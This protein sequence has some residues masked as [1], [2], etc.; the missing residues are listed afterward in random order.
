MAI[1]AKQIVASRCTANLVGAR[2]LPYHLQLMPATESPSILLGEY[3]NTQNEPISPPCPVAC[4]ANSEL[5]LCLVR[6]SRPPVRHSGES[7]NPVL[8]EYGGIPA[9]PGMIE[10]RSSATGNCRRLRVCPRVG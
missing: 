4:L 2:H 3:K 7:R 10:C 9:C 5:A 8:P 1:S 6:C